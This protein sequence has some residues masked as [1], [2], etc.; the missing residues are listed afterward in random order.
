M[1]GWERRTKEKMVCIEAWREIEITSGSE[2]GK[3]WIEI[4]AQVIWERE[5]EREREREKR[6]GMGLFLGCWMQKATARVCGSVCVCAYVYLYA[7]LC[8][9]MCDGCCW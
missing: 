9:S 5:S 7:W 1:D 2:K 3:R 8:V 4:D 6:S